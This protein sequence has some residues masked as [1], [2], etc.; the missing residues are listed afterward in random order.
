MNEAWTGRARVVNRLWQIISAVSIRTK[1]LGIVLGLVVLLGV[2]TTLVARDTLMYVMEQELELRAIS[3]ANDLA[4]RAVDPILVNNLYAL[5]LLTRETQS[6]YPDIRYAFVLDTTGQVL[7]HTFDGGF[8]AGLIEA[9]GPNQ[10]GAYHVAVLETNEGRV[11]DAAAPIFDGRA[12]T[13]RIGF[14]EAPLRRTIDVTTSQLLLATL[15]VS[16]FGIA[17]AIFLTWTLTRPILEITEAAQA[18]GRGD[19]GRRVTRWANDE[20]GDLAEAFNAM[21]EGLE[22][23]GEV[24]EERERLRTTLVERVIAAQEEERSRIARDL[25]DQTSQSLASLIVQLK[26]VETAPNAR[27][28]Q[29]SLME[30]REQLRTSLAE[31]RRMALDLRPGVLDDL[32]LVDAIHWFAERCNAEGLNIEVVTSGNLEQLPGKL[33]VA[34]YRVA[35][36]ALSNVMRHSGATHA[37]VKVQRVEDELFLEIVDNGKGFDPA[38][39]R[40]ARH[41]MGLFGMQERVELLGGEFHATSGV[42]KGVQIVARI[43]GLGGNGRFMEEQE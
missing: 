36:E 41:A 18:V 20:I 25:H 5:H 6:N 43:P 16:A 13:V 17:A 21:S 1:I 29:Q 30:L 38:A 7:A 11:W 3:A 28:R 40:D 2:G 42:G 4:S 8:P 37:Q 19:M 9:N 15:L 10:A 14:S 27:A 22:K 24:R 35:Q 33:S 31:V 23:A 26:L 12:G 39:R 32:G 34:V